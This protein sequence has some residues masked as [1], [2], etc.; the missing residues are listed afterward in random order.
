MSELN[1][2]ADL[3]DK[4]VDQMNILITVQATKFL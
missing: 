4:G 3:S 2:G 1:P